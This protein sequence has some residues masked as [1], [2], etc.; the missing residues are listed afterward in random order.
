MTSDRTPNTSD[1][2]RD[3]NAQERANGKLKVEN[4]KLKSNTFDFL[5]GTGAPKYPL[6]QQTPFRLRM[7]GAGLRRL[8][9]ARATVLASAAILS[10]SFWQAF[11]L[12]KGTK[13]A[14]APGFGLSMT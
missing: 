2:P 6:I 1:S 9:L 5:M 4:G 8:P 3:T 13:D 11:L 12:T 14:A 10:R 7:G